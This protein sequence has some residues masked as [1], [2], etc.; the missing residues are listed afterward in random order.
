MG[1][2]R[3]PQTSHKKG[4]SAY[5]RDRIFNETGDGFEDFQ[6]NTGN[7]DLESLNNV[8]PDGSDND[9]DAN[10]VFEN[11]KHFDPLEK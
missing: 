3:R 9:A 1:V 4:S 5:R 11:L 2:I 7:I 8:L 6:P 10:P